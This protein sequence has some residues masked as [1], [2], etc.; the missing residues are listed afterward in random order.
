MAATLTE[1]STPGRARIPAWAHSSVAMGEFVFIPASTLPGGALGKLW[2]SDEAIPLTWSAS[3]LEEF[4]STMERIE[5]D[6]SS[7]W[8]NADLS[9]QGFA[10]ANGR[11]E[12]RTGSANAAGPVVAAARGGGPAPGPRS[13][14][15]GERAGLRE[16]A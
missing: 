5:R 13:T 16:H 10:A 3:V 1:S 14:A 7:S 2:S 15:A 4:V 8:G 12:A 6:F 11:P 9:P